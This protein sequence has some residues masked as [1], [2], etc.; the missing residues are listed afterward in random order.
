MPVIVKTYL[1]GEHKYE[2]YADD[3]HQV[4]D[5]LYYQRVSLAKVDPVNYKNHPLSLWAENTDVSVRNIT[6]KLTDT[7]NE[8]IEKF[9]AQMGI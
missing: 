8:T 9:I 4:T 6:Q 2:V 5:I 7:D 3:N 1:C